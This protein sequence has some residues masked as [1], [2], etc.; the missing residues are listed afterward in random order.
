MST[1]QALKVIAADIVGIVLSCFGSENIYVIANASF[2]P[3]CTACGLDLGNLIPHT[4]VL[5]SGE[6]R[7]R[8]YI[9][10]LLGLGGRNVTQH[11]EYS[12]C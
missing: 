1:W 11:G 4:R 7:G 5:L 12:K 10:A 9:L 2:L 8:R 3:L 6:I